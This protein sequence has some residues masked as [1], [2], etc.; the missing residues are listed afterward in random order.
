[1]IVNTATPGPQ[2]NA[3]QTNPV[4]GSGWKRNRS[5]KILLSLLILFTVTLGAIWWL[6]RLPNK[7]LQEIA[8]IEKLGGFVGRPYKL[9]A[10]V[11]KFIPR[12]LRR[13][14]PMG[15][16]ITVGFIGPQPTDDDLMRTFNHF[17]DLEMIQLS[18]TLVT[19]RIMGGIS[20]QRRLKM[21]W[22]SETSLTDEGISHLS[23]NRTIT[24]LFL[25]GTKITD[26]GVEEISKMTQIHALTIANTEVTD[27]SIDFL[28]KIPNLRTLDIEGTKISEEGCARL[29]QQEQFTLA[30]GAFYSMKAP[31]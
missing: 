11:Q 15:E 10:S 31:W 14:S 1:M 4:Q 20:K 16:A 8:H 24:H 2:E 18:G 22:L 27:A 29:K 13:Y 17:Q 19:D 28:L 23:Q 3:L 26:R 21:L 7:D 9:P 6:T 25:N 30:P 5:R 12:V